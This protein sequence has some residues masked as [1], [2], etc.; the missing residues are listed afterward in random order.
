MSSFILPGEP[1]PKKDPYA[2][3]DRA[4]QEAQE[5]RR[6]RRASDKKLA[7]LKAV[8]QLKAWTTSMAVEALRAMPR[9]LQQMYLLAEEQ[10]LNRNEVTRFFPAV[11]PSTREAWAE[12]ATPPAAKRRATPNQRKDA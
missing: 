7:W 2:N 3:A 8:K 5:A 1:A 10:G 9:A 11:A 12:F 4:F 6:G